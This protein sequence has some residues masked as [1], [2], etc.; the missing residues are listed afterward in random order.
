[1]SPTRRQLLAGMT[2]TLAGSIFS[3]TAP[4][5]R[6]HLHSA[7]R[8]QEAVQAESAPVDPLAWIEPPTTM[9][10]HYI[11]RMS[12]EAT[13]AYLIERGHDPADALRFLEWVQRTCDVLRFRVA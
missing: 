3:V 7:G 12:P 13:A 11:D 6:P 4:G 8:Y 5:E 9:L 1:M 2:A 10:T